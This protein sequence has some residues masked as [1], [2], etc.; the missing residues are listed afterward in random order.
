VNQTSFGGAGPARLPTD[1]R[2]LAT[3][4]IRWEGYSPHMFV[5]ETGQVTTGVGHRLP[6]AAAAVALPWRHRATN[7]AATPDEIRSAFER[8]RAQ[9][10]G[11]KSLSY[12]FAS[13]LVL[14]PGAAGGLAIT[15]VEGELLPGLRRL[16][17]HFDRY[18]L[19][20]QRALVDIAY[21]VGLADLARF[22]NLLAACERGD[23]A[24]AAEHCHRRAARQIRNAATRALFLE[25]AHA[26]SAGAFVGKNARLDGG[27]A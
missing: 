19:S 4:L 9:G 12:R 14:P 13:D 27:G 10:P 3:E 21:T 25:A 5:D 24:T 6:N 16:F 26:S 7:L 22:R 23:F 2:A 17:V 15:R 1:V 18:P 11:A 8:V 20:A